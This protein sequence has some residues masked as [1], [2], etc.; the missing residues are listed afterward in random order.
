M[1]SVLTI[2]GCLLLCSCLL[3]VSPTKQNGILIETSSITNTVSPSQITGLAT[4]LCALFGYPEA[5]PVAGLAIIG[6]IWA[7]RIV[8][9]KR[10]SKK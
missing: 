1:K 4:E 7:W 5:G 3:T 9:N 2:L 10:K 8:R 6:A